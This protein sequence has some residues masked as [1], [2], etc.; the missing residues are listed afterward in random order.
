[1]IGNDFIGTG[2][3]LN[4]FIISLYV[5]VPSTVISDWQTRRGGGV[6]C[7]NMSK[8]RPRLSVVEI[9]CNTF[10]SSGLVLTVGLESLYSLY[11]L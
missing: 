4:Y 3:V 11:F 7:T 2:K 6:L 1:M 9:Q 5:H 10:A 8:H